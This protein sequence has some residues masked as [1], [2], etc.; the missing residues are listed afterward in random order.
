METR[1]EDRTGE[2]VNECTCSA[3]RGRGVGGKKIGNAEGKEE[4][5]DKR[6]RQGHVSRK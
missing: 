4:K 5:N 6:K 1:G 2:M 3:G